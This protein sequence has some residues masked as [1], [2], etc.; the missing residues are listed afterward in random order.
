MEEGLITVFLGIVVILVVVMFCGA[1]HEGCMTYQYGPRYYCDE[2]DPKETCDTTF[3]QQ[4]ID[5][6][7]NFILIP[8]EDCYHKCIRSHKNPKRTDD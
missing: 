1:I 3:I 7:G 5:D 4:P 6:K 8:H 2:Y